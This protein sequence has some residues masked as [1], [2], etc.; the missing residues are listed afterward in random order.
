[1]ITGCKAKHPPSSLSSQTAYFFSILLAIAVVLQA[2]GGL[3]IR[4]LYRDNAWVVS[5][6]KGTDFESL[7]LDAP[8]LIVSLIA[9][10]RGSI[11]ARII[12][13]G[14]VYYVFYNN[15]YYLFSAFN[16]FFLLYVALF[17]LSSCALIALLLSTDAG[18]ISG[19]NRSGLRKTI[20]V[21]MFANAATLSVMWIG[22]AIMFIADGKLPKLI[23]DTGAGT[24]M[25]AIC[26]LT[27]VVPPLVLGGILLW[28]GRP[29]GRVIATA[30][31]VQCMAIVVDLIVT[32]PF[33]AAAGVNDAWAMVPLWVLM[34]ASFLLPLMYLLKSLRPA[35]ANRKDNNSIPQPYAADV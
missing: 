20:S 10:I 21:I 16:R 28:R 3:F 17:I 35:G 1:M 18:E 4:G 9:T 27:L 11:R 23:S 2:A 24:Q 8:V 29:W 31:L 19:V 13:M 5:V 22:Q 12:L 6:F 26:D 30:M 33:Q 7:I 32:P 14:M 15:M 25:V 34:G